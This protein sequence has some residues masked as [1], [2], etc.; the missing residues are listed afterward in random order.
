[1]CFC[2][3]FQTATEAERQAKINHLNPRQI[4]AMQRKQTEIEGVR[5]VIDFVS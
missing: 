3:Q 2:S 4:N 1:M 5:Y